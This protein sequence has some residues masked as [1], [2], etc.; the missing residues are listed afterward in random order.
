[1]NKLSSLAFKWNQSIFSSM[2]YVM[3]MLF[4]HPV[5]AEYKP[6][7]ALESK[8]SI[9]EKLSTFLYNTPL[10]PKRALEQNPRILYEHDFKSSEL[11]AANID[12]NRRQL[13]IELIYA[14]RY[15][16]NHNIPGLI[17]RLGKIDPESAEYYY[18]QAMYVYRQNNHGRAMYLV[19]KAIK[20]NPKYARAWNLRGLLATHAG[21][22]ENAFVFF[23]SALKYAPFNPVYSYNAAFLH[24]KLKEYSRAEDRIVYALK[25]KSNYAEGYYLLALVHFDQKNY[26]E[27]LPWFNKAQFFGYENKEFYIKYAQSA[28]YARDL[29]VQYELVK[30]L[31]YIR[32][33]EANEL[34]GSFFIN[35]G[36]FKKAMPLLKRVSMSKKTNPDVREKYTICLARLRPDHIHKLTELKVTDTELKFLQQ[37]FQN[38]VKANKTTLQI[39]DQILNPIQ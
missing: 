29:N 7:I 15:K 12:L 23:D 27:A 39:R 16:V 14:F 25:A 10:K 2:L 22:N 24:Y 33:I 36:E 1:M 31:S 37:T 18:F 19:N 38:Q 20:A 30:K 9:S 4:Y 6:K 28:L 26:K 32:T 11:A 5:F 35:F 21:N 3:I 17:Y 13:I 8:K 34:L